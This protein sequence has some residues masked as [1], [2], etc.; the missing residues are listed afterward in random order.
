MGGNFCRL[1]FQGPGFFIVTETGPA[2]NALFLDLV[3]IPGRAGPTPN[4]LQ[5]Y[6]CNNVVYADFYTVSAR[7][8][9]CTFPDSYSWQIIHK[10]GPG[11]CGTI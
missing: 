2:G 7:L 10:A 11:V 9:W 8:A 4:L 1:F 5:L 3:L 6:F